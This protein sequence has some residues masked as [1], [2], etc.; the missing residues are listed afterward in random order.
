VTPSPAEAEKENGAA[1]PDGGSRPPAVVPRPSYFVR[2]RAY[3]RLWVLALI[4]LGLDQFT[5]ALVIARLPF[6][7]MGREDTAVIPGFFYLAH[8]GNTG[9]AW[10]IFSGRSL[11]LA[12]VGIGVLVAVFFWRKHLGL[13]DPFVQ[14][15]FGLFVGGSVG[16]II[17]R[18][19]LGHVVDFL[20]F[21]FGSYPFPT[22]NVADSAICVGVFAYVI[23]S[24]KQPAPPSA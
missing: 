22:F 9:G 21:R 15:C 2:L 10:S 3:A 4:I 19:R 18:L 17:D 13:R 16:N 6:G 24:L 1:K 14:W 12:L 23:W 20:D 8:V 11:P 7:T 5:K